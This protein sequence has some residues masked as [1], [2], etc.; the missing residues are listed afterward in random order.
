MIKTKFGNATLNQYGYY[1]IS[2][3]KEGNCGK[4][5]HRLIFEDYYNIDLD[6]EFPEGVIVHHIDGNKTNNEMWN[7]D[8]MPLKE[9]T[10]LHKTGENHH[11]YGKPVTH[12]T[13]LNQSKKTSETG[14]F[15]VNKR[16]DLTCT[17]G[18]IWVYHYIGEDGKTKYILRVNLKDLKEKV[19]SEGLEWEIVDEEKAKANGLI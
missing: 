1:R 5:L 4:L 7:L 14:Y 11:Q 15:R 10:S 17:Q 2:S 6:E 12:M 9:H 16:K 8:V 13:K 3:A 18:F 19:L